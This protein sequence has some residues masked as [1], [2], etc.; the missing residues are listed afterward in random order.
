[1]RYVPAYCLRE[2]MLMGDN[3][4]GPRGELMLT[5]GTVLSP[6]NIFSINRLNFNGLYVE[7]NLSKDIE[8][9]SIIDERVR[10][11]TIRAF[12]DV[13]IQ[14]ENGNPKE[15]ISKPMQT[16]QK[17]IEH[18]VDE[19]LNSKS[20]MINMI[21]MK[22][23][24]DYT[25]H[26]SVNVAVISIVIGV[27]LCLKRSDLCNLGYGALLHDIG[28]VFVNKEIL[29]KPGKLTEEEFDAIKRHPS[30]GYDYI[31]KEFL[32]PYSAQ[33]AI[34]DHHEKFDGTGYPH[35]L[36]G[37]AISQ[38]GRIISLADVYDAL[39]SERPYRPALLPSEAMEYIMGSS[40]MQ[41]DPS[42]VNIFVKKVAPYPT[43]TIVRLSNG[44][45]GIVF[46]NL[47]DFCM[48]PKIRVFS[49][50]NRDIEPFELDLSQDHTLN[51][52][53]VGVET[54]MQNIS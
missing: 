40:G 17:Q 47:E 15:K 48:R 7:D 9:A 43:G 12:K 45:V 26:H 5:K 1:M 35:G 6:N 31:T 25:Y 53:V 3:L 8:I 24:D 4:Y 38:F 30:D 33:R 20:L 21:D 2:G 49:D 46:E 23:F 10:V 19:V 27:A 44:M 29:N 18:I 37:T 51:I 52:T 50:K 39:T 42:L 14:A 32:M 13:Y 11:E 16:A 54:Q 41:F 28:K 34:I 36:K 22:V